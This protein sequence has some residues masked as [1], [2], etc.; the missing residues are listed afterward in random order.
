M[1]ALLLAAP[2][3]ASASQWV[4]LPQIVGVD[5]EAMFDQ[6]KHSVVWSEKEFRKWLEN[7]NFEIGNVAQKA[8]SLQVQLSQL[9]DGAA[10]HDATKMAFEAAKA[11]YDQLY[12]LYSLDDEL[13]EIGRRLFGCAIGDAEKN[14]LEV[15]YEGKRQ[16]RGECR[17]RYE[18]I[19]IYAKKMADKAQVMDTAEDA[20]LGAPPQ[21]IFTEE[22]A[23][24][25]SSTKQ[26]NVVTYS[27][28]VSGTEEEA[29]DSTAAEKASQRDAD[30]AAKEHAKVK[31]VGN[32]KA[33]AMAIGLGILAL[34]V[35]Y[36]D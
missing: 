34:V 27:A 31:E 22:Q 25:S 13:L 11:Q 23:G 12:G 21:E 36:F 6:Y 14:A 30:A 16:R 10:L 3:I 4:V 20:L 35:A 5:V 7:R 33:A 29:V 26:H 2:L 28:D 15:E 18:K 1:A 9:E 8:R 19:E 24:G 32:G 17:T